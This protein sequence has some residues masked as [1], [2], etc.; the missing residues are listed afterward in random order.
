MIYFL[1]ASALVKR[2]VKEVGSDDVRRL[3]RRKTRLATSVLAGV[4]IPCALARRA[5][6][7]DLPLD[8]AREHSRRVASDLSETHAVAARAPV[9]EVAAELAWRH[10][11]RAYDAVQLA[12]AV[13]LARESRTAVTFVC[14]DQKLAAA[15]ASCDQVSERR[16]SR[17]LVSRTASAS[18]RAD[19]C[20]RSASTSAEPL[21]ASR[22]RRLP[23]ARASARGARAGP[24]A[25]R[26]SARPRGSR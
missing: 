24:P 14:A 5:R 21:I 18:G 17:A 3:V 4:E 1:D 13:W 20:A 12:S 6:E 15:A 11:L 16:S 7:G 8:A 25:S 10:P 2:Y 19:A 22:S 26:A 23:R 9:L